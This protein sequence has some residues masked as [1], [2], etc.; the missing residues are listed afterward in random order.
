M[1]GEN[2]YQSVWKKKLS[3]H[4]VSGRPEIAANMIPQITGERL[5]DIGCGNGEIARFFGDR[6][7]EIHG[8][9]ISDEALAAAKINGVEGRRT[10]LNVEKLSYPDDYFDVITCLDVIEHIFDTYHLLSEVRRTL[11][12]KGTFVLS[13][14]NIGFVKFRISLLL[15]TFPR[16][17]NDTELY[18]GGHIHYFTVR[19]M[20][21]LLQQYGFTPIAYSGAGKAKALKSRFPNLLAQD[22]FIASTLDAS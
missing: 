19:E 6:F 10:N 18:D 17:S 11:R 14:P 1:F 9:D 8:T 16:T 15:G 20:Q 13:F 21:H 3:G 7:Q 12:P 2:A 5:L 22:A 4:F